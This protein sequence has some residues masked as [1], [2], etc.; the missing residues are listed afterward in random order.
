MKKAG[1]PEIDSLPQFY[2]DDLMALPRDEC[3]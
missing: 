1:V 2:S 3:P